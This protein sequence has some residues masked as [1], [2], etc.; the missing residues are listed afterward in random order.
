M[1]TIRESVRA[2]YAETATRLSQ[3]SG[4]CDAGCCAGS[5]AVSGPIGEEAYSEAAIA[6]LGL[7]LG[8]SLGCGNPTMLAELHP[9]A[10]VLDLGR[11]AGLDVVLPARRVSSGGQGSGVVMSG[12]TRA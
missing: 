11:R 4:C 9:G 10:V 12:A 3:S 1:D 8:A 7:L 2:K 6:G 5:D